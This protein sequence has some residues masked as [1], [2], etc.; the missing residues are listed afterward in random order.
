MTL[1]EFTLN[2]LLLNSAAA[3]P[4]ADAIV[5]GDRAYSY[6]EL[7]AE[8]RRLAGALRDNGVKRGDRVGVYLEKSWTSVVAM[9]GVSYAD[10][11]FVNLSPLLKADQVQHIMNNCEVSAII[12]DPSMVTEEPLPNVNLA[13]T[14]GDA[15]HDFSWSSKTLRLSDAMDSADPLTGI[16]NATS[17]DLAT[18]IYTSGSTGRAKGIMLTHQNVVAGAQIVNTYLENTPEDRILCV[19]PFNFDA[20]LNQFTTMLRIGGTAVLQHSLLPGDILKS[21]RQQKITGI[22]GVP[23]LWA[24]LM[25]LRRSL[26]REPLKYLRYISNTG[27][28]IPASHL[29]TLKGM[30]GST[31]IYLM[32]GLTEAFRSTYLPPDQLDRGS[33]CI[34]KAIPN[35]DIWVVRPDGTETA[36]GEEGE[37]IHR[38]PT[39][40]LG[41]WGDEEK[42]AAVYKPNPFAPEGTLNRDN[43]VYS[44]DIVTRDEDGFMYFVGRRDEQIKTEGYRVS[45]QE[46]EDLLCSMPAVHQAAVF[47]KKD[48]A[49]GHRIVAV[50]SLKSD[51]TATVEEI[52]GFCADKAP[53]YMIPKEITVLSDL[54]QTSSGKLD[55]SSLKRDYATAG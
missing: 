23:P 20:G 16:P 21:L 18:I 7:L 22:A 8:S 29:E 45:P 47:G 12:I 37:L 53:H 26:K 33:S 2:H 50:L 44:G 39:V 25:P 19:L 13:L 9:L 49:L 55:R 41:Y 15:S 48:G 32:Y 10:A 4:Q 54:P 14:F 30:L 51:E 11:V 35:T 17:N 43:V 34:G 31:K 6:S 1:P 5:D 36:P 24:V 28:M 38:G 27:G 42:T 3:R 46:V 52:K 40:A